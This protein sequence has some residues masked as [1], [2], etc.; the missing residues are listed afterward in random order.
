[1]PL[2]LVLLIFHQGENYEITKK[3][4]PYNN[5]GF[6]LTCTVSLQFQ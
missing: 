5:H 6:S 1:M 4:Q 2:L 3:D